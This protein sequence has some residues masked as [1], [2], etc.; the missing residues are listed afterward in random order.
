MPTP[1]CSDAIK[2]WETCS[3]LLQQYS[4]EHDQCNTNQVTLNP[5]ITCSSKQKKT[6]QTNANKCCNTAKRNLCKRMAEVSCPTMSSSPGFSQECK[7]EKTEVNFFNAPGAGVTNLCSPGQKLAFYKKFRNCCG[8]PAGGS[9]AGGNTGLS[10]GAIAGIVGGV[11]GF[12]ILVAIGM[13]LY[14]GGKKSKR[15]KR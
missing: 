14:Q 7:E 6:M 13:Y 8:S 12:I 3:T 10:G 5:D 4:L 1:S 9:P 15:K 11:V 2:Q